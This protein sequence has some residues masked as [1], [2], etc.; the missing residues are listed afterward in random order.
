MK[1]IYQGAFLL[2]IPF[3]LISCSSNDDSEDSAK[4]LIGS[5]DYYIVAK[6]NK[7]N[8]I[9]GDK[10]NGESSFSTSLSRSG[11]V[12]QHNL[13][14]GFTPTWEDEL[15]SSDINFVNFHENLCGGIEENSRFN[16][17]FDPGNYDFSDGNIK[18]VVIHLSF[19]FEDEIYYSTKGFEQPTGSFFRI[20]T[21]EEA[22]IESYP[23]Y[24]NFGQ[25]LT[26][27]FKARM[28]NPRNPEDFIDVN[29][30]AFKIRIE[31]WYEGRLD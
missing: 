25:I 18:G 7:G 30:G 19:S 12:C 4:D 26:G 21:S 23:G 17:F 16:T 6:T 29:S 3:F 31:S 11:G 8:I 9:T 15:P 22:N 2:L 20:T 14:S 1:Y 5:F 28:F 24:Y 27:E 10:Y 13:S